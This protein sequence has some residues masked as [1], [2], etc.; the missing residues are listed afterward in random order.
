MPRKTINRTL[1]VFLSVAILVILIVVT[2]RIGKVQ[3]WM[4]NRFLTGIEEKYDGKL[5]VA[6]VLIRWP[7][8]IELQNLLI[9]DALNDTLA[10]SS[11]I[12][13]SVKKLDLDRNNLDLSR[14]VFDNP[15]IKLRQLP[16]GQMNYEMFLEALKSGDSTGS[17]KPFSFAANEFTLRKGKFQYRKFGSLTKPG[18]VNWDN[19]LLTD[20]EIAVK[21]FE[22]DGSTVKA[23]VEIVSF[24][25]QSGFTLNQFSAGVVIDSIGIHTD[26]LTLLTGNSLLESVSA[27]AT[28]IWKKSGRPDELNL[29]IVLGRK[30][31]LSPADLTLLSGI[32]TGLT[33]PLEISGVFNGSPKNAR[34]MNASLNWQ[35]LISFEGDLVYYYPGNLQE[36]FFDLNT[37]S[38]ALNM[39]N[40]AQNVLSG[41]IPGFELVVPDL[42][43]SLGTVEYS[44]VFTGKF[45]HF[46]TSGSWNFSGCE[47]ATNLQVV[48]NIP[49]DGFNFKGSVSSTAFNPDLL[50]DEPS[51]I[52]GV[53]FNLNVDGVWDGAD[54]VA[55]LMDGKISQFS[56]NGYTF[57]SLSIDGKATAT[58]FDGSLNMRDPSLNLDL[59]GSFDFGQKKPVLDFSLD[60]NKAD[61]YALN[62][63]MV[64]T[65]SILQVNMLGS[66]T[67]SAIDDMDGEIRV[68]NSSYTN[69]WGKLPITEL[70]LSSIPE[71]GRRRI[72]MTSEYLDVRV[73]GDVHLDGLTAQVKSL[74]ARFVPALTKTQTVNP[75]HLNNFAFN[76]QIKNAEP[77]TRVL[78]P[79]F[80]CKDNTHISGFYNAAGQTIS[81]EGISPQFVTAGVQFTGLDINIQSR[82]DSLVLSGGLNKIQ[83]D[84]NTVFEKIKLEVTLQ[85]NRLN[86]LLNW[87]IDGTTGTRGKVGCAGLMAQ[88]EDGTLKGLFNF[89]ASEM[90]LNDSVW[91]IEPF[92][93]IADR[94]KIRVDHFVLAHNTENLKLNG[95]ISVNPSD[96]LYV[97]FNSVNLDNMSRITG[98]EDFRLR[99]W[100]TGEARL[101]DMRNNVK[102]LTEA[103]IDSLSVNGQPMGLTTL[104]SRSAGSGEPLLMDVLIQRGSIKTLLLHGQYNPVNESL[105]FSLVVDKL[106]MDIA[107]PF[108]NDELK[109]VKGLATGTVKISGTRKK[110]LVYGN[111]LMQKASFIVNYLNSRFYFTHNLV[112]TP[113]AFTVSKMDMQDDEGNHAFISGAVR[114]D[115]FNDIRLDFDLNFK[116]FILLN[117]IESRNAGYW[118][119]GYATGVGSIRGPLR[120]LVIDVSART[121]PKTKFFV[122]VYTTD[123]ARMMDFIT[124]VD[125]PKEEADADLLDFSVARNTG[126][127]V[128]LYGSTVNIDL[129]VTPDAEV[130]LI[131]D[132][133]VG[134]VIHAKGN[135]NLRV[136]IPPT[137]GFTLT[138]DYTIEQ[139]DYQFTLQN[140]PVKK[141]QIEP[142]A[143]LKWTGDVSNAQLDIDAVYRTKAA[144]YDLL[145]DESNP[146]FTQRLPVECHLLMSGYLEAPVVDFN[147]VLPPT[148]NDLARSQLQNLSKEEMSKQVISLL[149]LNRFT[150]LQGTGSGTASMYEKAGLST[151][152]EVLSNQLN[153]WLSQISK[154]FDVGF[155]YR[156]GDQLTSDEVEVALS[157]QFLNNRMTINVNGNVDVRPTTSNASQL[158]GDV[159]VEYKIKQ[160]GKVR[161]KAFTR[162]N[163]HLLY[164]YAPYT[165]GVGLFYREEF[166]TFGDLVR[167]YRDKWFRK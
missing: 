88:A 116:D 101:Y 84:R 71:L 63:L 21:H 37:R 135:G 167:K 19:L 166:D 32:N 65:I 133:K 96:T 74:I 12:R 77:L 83:L 148:S 53:D 111:I 49:V 103:R 15:I 126:Y 121:S 144:L 18:Q 31:Y 158:V 35:N 106:R 124:Y 4:I 107:N 105:D 99:G 14:I 39:P 59:T 136:Y 46:I 56:L 104:S 138:G 102:F 17:S 61:L 159:E 128:N 89:P 90:V 100:M 50:L 80:Q 143:T 153:Y 122:P 85:G 130:Q 123:E 64:D 23:G 62:L 115:K 81:I 141:L 5:T 118:G 164:E 87:N 11:S 3:T 38:L 125:R 51:G 42:L 91:R 92:Q 151:T 10:Y 7:N 66:F 8:R 6:K 40:L 45:E 52:T 1:I 43:K 108:V 145:Q 112:I 48:K 27:N 33:T 44:G 13:L 142:G 161:L 34:L 58:K 9:L 73:V 127:E 67:G 154:D 165:Q 132:S 150:P 2:I 29:E 156:P 147:I 129:E 117:E 134:D 60:I 120:S 160:S 119:R 146:D 30:S 113:D 94:E 93:I 55:A 86:A 109:D 162:A 139:G 57:Q 24:A 97:S 157:K 72:S 131:F 26:N 22:L 114:H 140:M 79:G 137:S 155:N 41:Q 28:G 68:K 69:S 163:D 152:T 16:S 110:P 36:A 54:S 98:S 149:I 25:E 47:F 75:D 82:G 95:A 76:I 20:I 70:T 78:L